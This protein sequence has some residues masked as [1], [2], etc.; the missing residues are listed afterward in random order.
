MLI[1]SDTSEPGRPWFR[2]PGSSFYSVGFYFKLSY[3][4]QRS[5]SSGICGS[6]AGGGMS[7]LHRSLSSE[8]AHV[9]RGKTPK[10]KS[11]KKAGGGRDKDCFTSPR[12]DGRMPDSVRKQKELN[13][14]T[15]VLFLYLI[16]LN[17]GVCAGVQRRFV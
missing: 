5:A 7:D 11:R 17:D 4:A 2:L 12:G 1:A 13:K 15:G 14:A 8:S 9:E 6:S 10:L 16:V 3:V